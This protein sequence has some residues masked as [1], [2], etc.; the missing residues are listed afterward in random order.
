M[1]ASTFAQ[2]SAPNL[3]AYPCLMSSVRVSGYDNEAGVWS[4][5]LEDTGTNTPA[6]QNDPIYPRRRGRRHSFPP[7]SSYSPRN[8]P[9]WGFPLPHKTYTDSISFHFEEDLLLYDRVLPDGQVFEPPKRKGKRRHDL[10]RHRDWERERIDRRMSGS[11]EGLLEDTAVARN[12]AFIAR[13]RAPREPE[14]VRA[15]DK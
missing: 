10:A 1:F 13:Y 9:R 6:A 4:W 11:F 3:R 15:S 2:A 5:K 12:P 14:V 8:A 7:P